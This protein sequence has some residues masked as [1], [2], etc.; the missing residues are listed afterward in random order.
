MSYYDRF[1][2]RPNASDPLDW[3]SDDQSLAVQRWKD[4]KENKVQPH[5]MDEEEEQGN[6][7]VY[8]FN[9]EYHIACTKYRST[10]EK[11]VSSIR[12]ESEDN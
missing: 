1:N 4:F 6:F 5:I 3:H 8:L 9:Q 12:S 10:L 2:N 11:K 7:I